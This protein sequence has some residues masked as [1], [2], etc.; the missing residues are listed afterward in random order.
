MM[1]A[2][3]GVVLGVLALL[4]GCGSQQQA[5]DPQVRAEL[6]ATTAQLGAAANQQDRPG[7]ESALQRLVSQVAAAQAGRKLDPADAQSI[8][9]A[10]NRVA[11]DVQT[12]AP[13]PPVTI[14]V[15]PSPSDQENQQ[16]R[17]KDSRHHGKG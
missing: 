3:V 15:S 10:A 2:R 14:T 17:G 16:D 12:L 7:A 1:L 13:P 11:Q 5:M 8:L 4:A 6:R 9:A